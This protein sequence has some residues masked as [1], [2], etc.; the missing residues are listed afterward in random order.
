DR[1]VLAAPPRAGE[2]VVDVQ[3]PEVRR[4]A[5][6]VPDA[7]GRDEP[8][9]PIKGALGEGQGPELAGKASIALHDERRR[10][11]DEVGATFAL[12]GPGEGGARVIGK[13]QLLEGAPRLAEVPLAGGVHR[14]AESEDRRPEGEPGLTRGGLIGAG[15]LG[16]RRVDRP[17]SVHGRGEGERGSG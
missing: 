4:A 12:D 15:A 5:R 1:A 8:A 11:A 9:E 2:P 6:E 17:G 13:R 16:V 14:G 10:V 7:T 3:S